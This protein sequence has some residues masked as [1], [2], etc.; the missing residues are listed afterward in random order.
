VVTESY[1]EAGQVLALGQPVV[2]IARSGDREAV[3]SVPE[4]LIGTIAGAGAEAELWSEPGRK[5]PVTLRELSPVADVATRTYEAHFT[6]PPD[7]EAV[8]GMSTSVTL[9]P[10]V[11]Q[12]VVLLPTSAL[13]D[14]G[15]GPSVWVVGE[16][17]TLEARP[18]AVTG[19][20][21]GSAR[22]ASGLARGERVVVLG[23]HR[24]QAGTPVRTLPAEG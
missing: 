18:V 13:I 11:A 21:A 9:A 15:S 19:Y 17:D 3:V 2:R 23:A 7:A 4:A 8:L 22:F 20:S 16:D 6:L 5:Y 12:P 14:T 24:L 10:A 1:A